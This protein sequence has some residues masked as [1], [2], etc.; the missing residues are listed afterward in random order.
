MSQREQHSCT[1]KTN[2]LELTQEQFSKEYGYSISKEEAYDIIHN[3]VAYTK[4]L[5][6]IDKSVNKT[7][8]NEESN[9]K[10]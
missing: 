10:E 9:C 4:V 2:L 7:S 8:Q 3:L 6:E 5:I 1:K